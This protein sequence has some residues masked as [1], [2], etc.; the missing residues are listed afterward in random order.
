MTRGGLI[1]F[2]GIAASG[3]ST[4]ARAVAQALQEGGLKTEVLDA[5]E[6]RKTIS[7]RLGYSQDER[8][9]NTWRL[10][11]ISGLLARHGVWSLVAA[12]SSLRRFRDRA[13]AHVQP[14]VEVHV[15]CSVEECRRRDPKGLY[16]RAA[17]GEVNDIAGWHQPFEAP[18]A[19]EVT[20][21][22]DRESVEE[23][24]DRILTYLADS[25]GL[26]CRPEP[27]PAPHL[28]ETRDYEPVDEQRVLLRLQSLGY[29]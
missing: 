12:V 22:T 7:P 8:D 18:L 14:F 24:A 21:R 10:A 25:L 17:R 9:L 15:D 13:R 1:W 4:L 20:V 6:V 5:D 29:L 27:A 16:A 19:A 26:P 23:S 28:A 11:Y 2:T 3:K